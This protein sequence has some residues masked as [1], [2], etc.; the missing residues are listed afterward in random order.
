MLPFLPDNVFTDVLLTWVECVEVAK[1]AT[2][3]TSRVVREKFLRIIRAPCVCMDPYWVCYPYIRIS[4]KCMFWMLLR[5]IKTTVWYDFYPIS[6]APENLDSVRALYLFG[7]TT[8]QKLFFPNLTELS[9]MSCTIDDLKYFKTDNISRLTIHQPTPDLAEMLATHFQKCRHLTF[10]DDFENNR[11]KKNAPSIFRKLNPNLNDFHYGGGI[12]TTFSKDQ[13]DIT[14][15]VD[16]CFVEMFVFD[17]I[18]DCLQFGKLVFVT[19]SG[20]R[21]LQK[22]KRKNLSRQKM[23][24]N[25]VKMLNDGYKVEQTT[26]EIP[27]ITVFKLKREL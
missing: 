12:H 3:I 26:T 20:S 23:F 2:A 4:L 21:H 13:I 6:V 5:G 27:M 11:N 8:K 17:L 7:T 10:S 15:Y 22:Q 14:M 24:K 9:C 19:L 18:D 16:L 25:L 1:L